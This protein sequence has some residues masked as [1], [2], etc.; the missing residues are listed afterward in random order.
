MEGLLCPFP[1]SLLSVSVVTI[2]TTKTE[3]SLVTTRVS[4]HGYLITV[5]TLLLLIQNSDLWYHKHVEF[6]PVFCL[7]SLNTNVILIGGPKGCSH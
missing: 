5:L 1:V 3:V 7:W 6:N 2:S 4:G